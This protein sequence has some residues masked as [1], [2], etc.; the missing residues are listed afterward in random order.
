MDPSIR[1]R[2]SVQEPFGLQERLDALPISPTHVANHIQIE[3]T[4]N[5]L[6][7]RWGPVIVSLP[8]SQPDGY[9]AVRPNPP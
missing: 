9:G 5:D 7:P 8:E 3:I 2:S 4:V 1:N 6:P